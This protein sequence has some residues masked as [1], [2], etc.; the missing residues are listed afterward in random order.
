MPS[1]SVVQS[2][3]DRIRPALQAEGGDIELIELAGAVARVR[4]TGACAG[5]PTA[6]VT[7]HMGVEAALR[8]L[9]PRLRVALV[10]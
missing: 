6:H 2:V 1:F 10:N 8:R 3:L 9:H 5:C 4:L 7:L